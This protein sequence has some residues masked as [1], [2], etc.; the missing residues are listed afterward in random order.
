M[1]ASIALLAFLLR[2]SFAW[3]KVLVRGEKFILHHPFLDIIFV[4]VATLGFILL[5]TT[6]TIR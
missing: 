5:Q 2:H 6:G 4:A 1:L 3:H